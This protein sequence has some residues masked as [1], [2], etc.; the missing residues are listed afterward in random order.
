MER[1]NRTLREGLEGETEP[2]NLLEASSSMARIVRRC[3][4]TRPHGALGYPPPLEYYRDDPAARFEQRRRKLFQARHRRR[5]RNL[6]PRQETMPLEGEAVASSRGRIVPL[7][8]TR[9][10]KSYSVSSRS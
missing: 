6:N 2:N 8:L 9:Y 4:E 1:A 7:R 3:N 10:S 5:E